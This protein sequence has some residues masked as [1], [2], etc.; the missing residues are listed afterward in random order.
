MYRGTVVV[1]ERP[2]NHMEQ[3][4]AEAL[5]FID[6]RRSQP[7]FLYLPFPAVHGPM[8]GPEPWLSRL[9]SIPS[10]NRRKY[11]ADLAQ[12]DD[13]I[14]RIM[15][16]LG[17]HRLEENTLIFFFSDNGGSGGSTNNGILRGNKWTLWEGGIRV[18]MLA[19]WKGHIPAGRVL[20]AP[21]M[22]IDVLPTALAAAGAAMP[23][24]WQI[25]GA[26]LLPYLA[27][28]AATAPHDA[29]YWRFGVQYA[30]RQGSWKLV[31]PHL[32]SLPRLFNL[33]DDPG[34]QTDLAADQ[35]ARVEAMQAMWDA[36][37]AKN[38]PPR[39][40]DHRWNGDGP[41]RASAP[42]KP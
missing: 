29:L 9:A 19:Q 27:D 24:E 41:R 34:E 21:V 22:Q 38:E 5:D 17:E 23:A 25:D 30:I 28:S 6:R 11:G 39:W 31:K 2:K 36:W 33:A 16:R 14:G 13:V 10:E 1:N 42:A 4:C 40:I 35:P 3:F 32:N 12:M 20:D 26:S 18:P 15:A 7:F 8:V 37:N